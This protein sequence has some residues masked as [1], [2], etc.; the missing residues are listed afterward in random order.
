MLA[1][2]SRRIARKNV[3]TSAELERIL[4][5]GS[6]TDA[7][8]SVTQATAERH[9][10]VYICRRVISEAVAQ[11]PFY[12]YDRNTRNVVTD[13][14]VAKLYGQRPNSWQT[15]FEYLEQQVGALVI[16]GNMLA[17]KVMAGGRVAE[18]I[19]INP[20]AVELKRVEGKPFERVYSVANSNGTKTNYPATAI[21]HVRLCT[22]DGWWG[23]SPV[24]QARNSFGMSIAIERYGSRF[25]KNQAKPGGVLTHPDVLS[26]K[27]YEKLKNDFQEAYSGENT[28]KVAILEEGMK[29]EPIALSNE[30]SQF[31]ESRKYQRVETA[32]IFGVPPHR[33]GDLEN[34]HYNNIE[35][36]RIEFAQNTILPI[37]R[38]IE[39]AI[40]RDLMMP[41]DLR[42]GIYGEFMLEAIMRGDLKSRYDAYSVAISNGFM[43]PNEARSKENMEPYDGGDEFRRPLNTGAP[44]GNPDT[45]GDPAANV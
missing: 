35:A 7:G 41:A 9:A 38:R 8:E 16:S 13:H 39:Q 17:F 4:R 29:F 42:A 2:L 34:A 25:F 21:H 18:L 1:W 28:H 5:G 11:L 27:A 23:V 26:A 6:D 33:V 44:G 12:V 31:L 19:P 32:T 10:T 43:S 40:L 36:S 14:P 22:R 24:E 15:P 30:D 20:N 3:T 37:C 45:T